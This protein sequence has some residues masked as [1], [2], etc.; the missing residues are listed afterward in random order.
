MISVQQIHKSYVVK[1]Q[2]K[3]KV[4]NNVSFEAFD[5]E[6]FGL[7]GPNGAGKTTTLRTIATLI[8]P[9]QG[10]VFVEGNDVV[11]K[12]R[13]VRNDIGFLTGDM[14]LTGQLS[15]REML[16]FFGNLNHMEPKEITKKIA[17]FA[18]ELDMTDFLDKPI[19]KLSSGMVQKTSIAVSILH[20]P[21]VI[22][23]DEPTSNLDVLAVKIVA[24]FIRFSREQGRCVLL[25]T[26]TLS[27][28]QRLCDRVGIIHEGSMLC[29]GKID[30]LLDTYNV[31]DLESLFFHLVEE[32]RNIK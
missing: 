28:A 23:F 31:S 2:G 1:K 6:V 20:D 3:K 17:K 9:D 25:S 14:K 4:L 7:L 16:H 18:S 10:R 19:A 11:A 15:S 26:H 12:G 29:V 22:I 27:E 13:Q 5:G 8:K 24:D 32:K 30:E 21:K